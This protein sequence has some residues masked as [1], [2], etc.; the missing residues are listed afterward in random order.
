MIESKS[1]DKLKLLLQWRILSND[2][3]P[4]VKIEFNK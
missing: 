2:V 3:V 1:T 4:E